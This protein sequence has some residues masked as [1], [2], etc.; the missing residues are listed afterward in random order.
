MTK[1][2]RTAKPTAG[3]KL[4]QQGVL[5][6]LR[7][8]ESKKAGDITL[9]EMDRASSAFTDYFVICSG[10]NPRQIQAIADEVE[11]TLGRR[12]LRPLNVEGYNRAEWILLDYFDFVVHIFSEH[13]RKFYDLERLWK[14]ARRVE[15][16]SLQTVARRRSTRRGTA[17][18]SRPAKRTSAKPTSKRGSPTRKR[19]TK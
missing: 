10:T 13:A 5:Q 6:A 1:P 11:E 3:A 12:G 4:N 19:K 9:L 15:V 16:S 17:K 8:C 7:A 14:S 2:A 18:L